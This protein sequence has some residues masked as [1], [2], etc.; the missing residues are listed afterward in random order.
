MQRPLAPRADAVSLSL[1]LALAARA[2]E[3]AAAG[4]DVVNMAVGEPDFPAP[5]EVSAAAAAKAASGDV[6]YTPAAGTPALRETIARHLSETRGVPFAPEQVVVCHS[7]KHALSTAALAQ[8][9]DGDEVLMPL[10]AW[11]SYMEIVKLAGAR[12]VTIPGGVDGSPDLDALEAACTERT[13]AVW[14]NSPSNPSGYVW[15][16][17]ELE[18]LSTFCAE[19]ELW[20]VSDEIYRRL[21]Y[22][23]REFVSPTSLGDAAREV[24]LV[25]DGASKTFAMTGYRIGFAAGPQRV[26]QAMARL[27][28]QLTGSPNAISQEAYRV[29]LEDE[30]PAVAEMV[31]TYRQRRDRLVAGLRGMGLDTTTPH[32]AFYVFPDMTA[33]LN[34]SGDAQELCA[35]LLEDEALVVVP[36]AAFGV[37]HHIRLSYALDEAKLDQALER[38]ARFLGL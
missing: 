24:T 23:E 31:A 35:N 36:G 11:V 28:S 21:T 6:R 20:L 18:R 27:N 14:I 26:V 30:P 34:G 2:K 5:P 22:G 13:R 25:V 10:P 12:P 9:T 17:A 7:A 15:S 29:A 38:L 3:L 32:G 16:R 19:R 8:L 1:T 37:P 33:H 4:R